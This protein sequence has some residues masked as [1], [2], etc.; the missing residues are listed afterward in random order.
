ML[1]RYHAAC[2]YYTRTILSMAKRCFAGSSATATGTAS[3]RPASAQAGQ[4]QVQDAI[5]ETPT[6]SVTGR[7]F[8]VSI[9]GEDYHY[10][11]ARQNNCDTLFTNNT[12]GLWPCGLYCSTGITI[13]N[14][15]QPGSVTL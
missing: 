6:N 10:Q 13:S 14:Q 4:A 2:R 5:F 15:T 9:F 11:H 8:L 7:R 12:M 3:H 1:L